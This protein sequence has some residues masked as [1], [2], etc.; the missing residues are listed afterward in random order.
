VYEIPSY[1]YS[2]A[3]FTA[4]DLVTPIREGADEALAA[5]LARVRA[6]VPSA[7]SVLRQGY[8]VD[9]ILSVLDSEHA[10]LLV[11][12]TH[13]RRGLPRALLG[14]VAEKLVRLAPVPVLTAHAPA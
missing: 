1:V 3:P 8:P 4:A 11:L 2:G 10:D 7:T 5:E 14:S 12:G 9:Q 6:R 13:G